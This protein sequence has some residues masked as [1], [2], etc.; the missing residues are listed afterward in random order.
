MTRIYTNENFPRP[1]ALSL[2]QL[3]H[4]VLTSQEAGN[5]GF[6]VPDEEVLRYATQENRVLLTLNRL[7]FK[8]LHG[9][10]P[11]HAGIIL[12]TYDSDF[13]DQAMR[14]H[15]LLESEQVFEGRL[16]RVNRG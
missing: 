8:R 10:N 11:D 15:Q 14:I 2:R 7:H 9:K 6:A 3:G 12:C 4:D 1:V 16:F 5:A 13:S